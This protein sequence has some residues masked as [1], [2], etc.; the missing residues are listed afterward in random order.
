ME[1]ARK[2][3]EEYRKAINERIDEYENNLLKLM[4]DNNGVK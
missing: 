1:I 2:S 4:I 3:T